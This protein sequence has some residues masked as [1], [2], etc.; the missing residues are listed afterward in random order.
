MLHADIRT[1]SPDTA[2]Q[3]I[4]GPHSLF[5]GMRSAETELKEVKN[6]RLAML[7][8]VGFCSQAAVRGLGPID[9]LKAHIADPWN[10][11]SEWQLLQCLRRLQFM[12]PVCTFV[13]S[14]QMAFVTCTDQT[15]SQTVHCAD[16]R[17]WCMPC[18]L[19]QRGRQGEL[20]DRGPAVCVAHHH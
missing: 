7:A 18:S 17:S 15:W 12:L 9:S 1:H 2:A 19:H 5:T 6:G 14:F 16:L 13:V 4:H 3:S 20:P 8:F 11:N 10:Q